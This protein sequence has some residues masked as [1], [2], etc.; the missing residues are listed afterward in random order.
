[1]KRSFACCVLW[2]FA[3]FVSM[4]VFSTG[5]FDSA[6]RTSSSPQ[7]KK[8]WIVVDGERFFVK[9]IGYS[10]CRPH[11]A[12]N[13]KQVDL[14]QC[15]KEFKLIREAG[16]NTL[17]TWK[18]LSLEEL[19]IAHEFG[20]QV[21]QGTWIEYRENYTDP[22]RFIQMMNSLKAVM[23]ESQQAPNVLLY[24][25]GNEPQP[26]QVFSIGIKNTERFFKQVRK[27]IYKAAPQSLVSMSNWVQCD[28]LNDDLWDI[29]ALNIYLYNPDSVSYSMGY[30]GYVH[31]LKR[32]RA[33]NRPLVITEMGLSV[34]PNGL[35][36]WG[37]GGNSE[38]DQKEGVLYMLKEAIA[39]GATGICIFEWIDEWWKNYNHVSDQAVHELGDPE[40]WFGM[41]YYDDLGEIHC[42]PL[43]HALKEFNQA[44]VIEPKDLAVVSESFNVEVTVEPDI[45]QV[46]VAVED[47]FWIPLAK[48][49]KHWFSGKIPA[50]NI[51][52][53]KIA[54]KIRASK[55][56]PS[57]IH[58]PLLV[59]KKE[60]TLYVNNTKKMK[61]PYQVKILL[62]KKTYYTQ[63]RLTPIR[64]RF[65]MTDAQGNP[66]AHQKVYNSIY[67][68]VLNQQIKKH[69]ETNAEGI[70]TE[71]YHVNEEGILT[72]AC[73]VPLFPHEDTGMDQKNA[74]SFSLAPKFGDCKHVSIFYQKNSSQKK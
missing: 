11:E 18:P 25:V 19:R 37:Y 47:D 58:A 13:Q 73:G 66:V 62:D 55:P 16:F 59:F 38:A 17:R 46:D 65:K 48:V 36:K 35:G 6:E 52:D 67:E 26:A 45:T 8:D 51:P 30:R 74:S 31:W 9:G 63:S 33:Q 39:G 61:T 14:D 20:F 10:N 70:A 2:V 56:N 23:N 54:F 15:R 64:I 32:T 29:S 12:P 21:I 72:I 7:V 28:F 68:P 34:S 53:G 57:A 40:E 5:R 22:D 41:A 24:L 71:F 27:S 50:E 42:R 69:S 49:S 3:L 1:M 44:I 60:Q 4:P 43:Y